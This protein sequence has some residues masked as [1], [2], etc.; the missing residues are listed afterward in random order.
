VAAEGAEGLLQY[1]R[2]PVPGLWRDKLKPDGAFV[3]EAAPA[4][5]FYHIVCAIAEM[6]RVVTAAT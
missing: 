2:T 1:L 5:S 4:S 3:E 6:D